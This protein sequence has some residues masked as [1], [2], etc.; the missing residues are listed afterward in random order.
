MAICAKCGE[1]KEDEFG[2]D[3]WEGKYCPACGGSD[4]KLAEYVNIEDIKVGERFRVEYVDIEKLAESIMAF[5]LLQYPV[6]DQENNLVAGGRRLQALERLQWKKIP[7]VRKH[8]I[9]ELK[10]REMELEENLQRMALTWQEETALKKRILE[11]KQAI[12]GVKQAGK[13]QKGISAND[14]AESLNESPSNFS[15]DV[16]LAEALEVMPELG[17]AKTKQEAFKMMKG[18]YE[19]LLVNELEARRASAPHELSTPVTRATEWFM[20]EDAISGLRQTNENQGWEYI[21]VDTPYAIMLNDVKKSQTEDSVI[22]H[23][24]LEWSPEDYVRDCTSIAEDLYRLS[25]DHCFMTWWFA[26]QWYQPLYQLLTKAG[27]NVRYIPAMWYAVG[28]AQTNA[29]E[30]NL[31]SSYEPFFVCSK[32]K[33]V[34]QQRG[35][36]N[37]FMYNKLSP[38]K[39]IHPTEK[40]LDLMIEILS[41]FSRP[42]ARCYSAFLGSGVDIRAAL[43]TDR[44][45][46]GRDLNEEVKKR[47]LV[48]VQEEFPK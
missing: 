33:P 20:V 42:G 16:R 41:T 31:A 27:W 37:V 12:Y 15:A 24:Y 11:I 17:K 35:R 8:N 7:I 26:I 10:L 40:P 14:I 25:S 32:G 21:N 38:D 6:L 34:L 47:F 18:L 48:K 22:E 5:G 44:M 9:S 43:K 4:S 2:V 19:K 30:V 23:N 36:S 1:K 46:E 13:N 3:R 39:K 29:P 28:G 45:L